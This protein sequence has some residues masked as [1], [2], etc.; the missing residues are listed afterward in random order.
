MAHACAQG[1]G[2]RASKNL[3]MQTAMSKL[4]IE[5]LRNC[6]HI[7]VSTPAEV[8]DDSSA[9]W[10]GGAYGL[11][12]GRKVTVLHCCS[13]SNDVRHD[14]SCCK[15]HQRALRWLQLLTAALNQAYTCTAGLWQDADALTA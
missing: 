12:S 15:E 9:I 6:L 3:V 13:K 1:V 2:D 5:S 4:V 8:D 14:S 10:K 7:L 11:H